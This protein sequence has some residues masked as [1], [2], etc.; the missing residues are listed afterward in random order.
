MSQVLPLKLS[1]VWLVP[2]LFSWFSPDTD[3][4]WNPFPWLSYFPTLTKDTNSTRDW[5]GLLQLNTGL[6]Q[7]SPSKFLGLSRDGH[8][9]MRNCP[10]HSRTSVSLS[11]HHILAITSPSEGSPDTAKCP[12]GG[13]GAPVENYCS[14]RGL[15]RPTQ[16]SALWP[17]C[18][19]CSDQHFSFPWQCAHVIVACL[20]KYILVL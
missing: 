10:G 2:S 9:A 18:S 16:T 15:P 14:R 8:L 7:S 11:G 6:V 13:K 5:C 12:L 20:A 17:V 19:C 1:L 3:F 4:C